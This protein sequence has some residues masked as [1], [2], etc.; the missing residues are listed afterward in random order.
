[1]I[2]T[3][4]YIPLTKCHSNSSLTLVVAIGGRRGRMSSANPS[5]RREDDERQPLLRSGDND[6]KKHYNLAGLSQTSFWVLVSTLIFP[7]GT[8]PS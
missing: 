4:S 6:E 2:P 8:V 1:M 3:V 5:N 7:L